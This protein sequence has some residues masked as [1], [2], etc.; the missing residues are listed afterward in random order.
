MERSNPDS[1]VIRRARIACKACNTR[2]VKCDAADGIPCWHCRTRQTSCE[3]I[4]SRRGRYPRKRHN[5]PQVED[6]AI[7]AQVSPRLPIEPASHP[8]PNSANPAAVQSARYEDAAE[9]E[10]VGG[11]EARTLPAPASEL[12]AIPQ[13]DQLKPNFRSYYLGASFSSSYII[14]MACHDGNGGVEPVKIHYP[15]PASLADGSTSRLRISP[16]EQVSIQDA[17]TMPARD[18]SDQLVRAFFETFHAA[19]PVIDRNTFEHL[20]EQGQASPLV[21]HTIYMVALTSGPDR[22]VRV[23]GYSDRTAARKAHY[24]RAKAL[25]DAD[26][27]ADPINIAAALHLLSFWWFGPDDQKDSWY[28][29]GCAVTLVQSLGI[30]RS[31]LR[32]ERRAKTSSMWK[33]IWW[34]I[35]IRDR[36]ASAALCRPC[37]IRD[38][39]CD[40]EHLTEN[41]LLFD[42]GHNQRLIPAQRDYH[43]SYFLE[44]SKLSIILGDIV[45]GEFSPRRPALGRFESDSLLKRLQQWKSQL[46]RILKNNSS[47]KS[48]GASFWAT[49]LDSS[50]RYACILLFRPKTIQS[51]FSTETYTDMQA[52]IAADSITRNAEDLLASGTMIYAQLHMVPSLFGALSIHTLV[53]SRGNSLHRQLAENKSRQCILALTELAKSWP[54]GMWI[55]K[56]FLNLMQ[57]LTSHGVFGASKLSVTTRVGFSETSSASSLALSTQQCVTSSE[58]HTLHDN[59]STLNVSGQ[60]VLGSQSTGTSTP[61]LQQPQFPLEYPGTTPDQLVNDSF[62]LEYLDSIIDFEALQKGVVTGPSIYPSMNGTSE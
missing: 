36:H 25:Y 12:E 6:A 11:S 32:P 18:V 53:I 44:I 50:Y 33:R 4:E 56:A 7:Q 14:E 24:L 42:K 3:L 34:S 27:E 5:R 41:D 30:H 29:Q 59:Q 62:W 51:L 46:P 49:M 58:T 47:D 15:I 17:L 13:G 37:R 2:R 9:V 1:P 22:L 60:R 61:Q 57:R 40:V 28:W 8:S 45:I 38:E 54:V 20:Y 26:Y 31:S 39:D 55:V 35:Y 43:T 21:L 10:H 23:A 52:R 19:N 48:M 16:V